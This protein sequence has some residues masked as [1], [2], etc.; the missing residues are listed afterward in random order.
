MQNESAELSI[1][2]ETTIIGID[3]VEQNLWSFSSSL[4]DISHLINFSWKNVIW[5][6]EVNM[7]NLLLNN[8]PV[9]PS[10]FLR[11][12]IA[13]ESVNLMSCNWRA[14]SFDQLS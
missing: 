7:E 9:D 1:V 10:F 3:F 13:K 11:V 12:N 6:S 4:E 14:D 8:A 5:L 2:K